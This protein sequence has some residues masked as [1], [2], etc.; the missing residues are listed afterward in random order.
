MALVLTNLHSTLSTLERREG[1]AT[2]GSEEPCT[3]TA[4]M[5]IGEAAAHHQT[6]NW[7][8]NRVR[9]DVGEKDTIADLKIN[10]GRT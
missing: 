4:A 2:E 5:S 9:L 7:F 6:F 8:H 10:T 1:D 3:A